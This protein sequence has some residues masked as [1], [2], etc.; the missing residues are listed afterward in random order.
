[1]QPK[2]EQTSR[3]KEL[4]LVKHENTRPLLSQH[5]VWYQELLLFRSI[6]FCYSDESALIKCISIIPEMLVC[7]EQMWLSKMMEY[8]ILFTPHIYVTFSF[9]F[10]FL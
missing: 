8:I 2:A 10:V 5:H 7:L 9:G 1:M 4:D 3:L 6:K